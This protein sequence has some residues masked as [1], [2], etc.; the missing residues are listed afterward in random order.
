MNVCF[1]S[2]FGFFIQHLSFNLNITK[3]NITTNN[4]DELNAIISIEF[5]KE[6]YL[7]KVEKALNTA[8]NNAVIKGFRKGFVPAGV[9]KK[10]YGNSILLDEL[11]KSVSEALNKH[12]EEAKIIC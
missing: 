3:V 10:M 11:N 8:K 6:D 12:I 7:P 5:K 4:T 1:Y 9:I 2:T